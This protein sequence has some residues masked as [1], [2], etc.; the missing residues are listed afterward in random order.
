M[1]SAVAVAVEDGDQP[2]LETPEVVRRSMTLFSRVQRR[3]KVIVGHPSY[4]LLVGFGYFILFFVSA[5]VTCN[6]DS[7]P[8]DDNL[9]CVGRGVRGCSWVPATPFA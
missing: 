4:D 2:L 9:L 7:D 3:L 1:S 6:R 5:F 8:F